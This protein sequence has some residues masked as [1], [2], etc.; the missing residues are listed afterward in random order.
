MPGGKPAGVRC[1]NLDDAGRC[2]IWNTPEY[3]DFCRGFR[4]CVEVCG[5]SRDEALR[6]LVVL[7]RLTLPGGHAG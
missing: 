3:P 1:V 5:D 6:R 2:R 4:P 7:E